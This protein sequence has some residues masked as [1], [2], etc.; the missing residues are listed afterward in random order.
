MKLWSLLCR[1][2]N[3]PGRRY[4][5]SDDRGVVF[6]GT[7]SECFDHL[8]YLGSDNDIFTCPSFS[9]SVGECR[10]DN[11]ERASRCGFQTDSYGRIL[12]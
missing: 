1:A 5:L 12:R 7:S 4:E 11:I 6:S 2:E 8:L 10:K 9:K 3:L